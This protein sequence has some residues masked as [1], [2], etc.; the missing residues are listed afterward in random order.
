METVAVI[1]IDLAKNVFQVHGSDATGRRVFNKSLRRASVAKFFA[2]LP[3]CLVGMEACGSSHYW[4]R[5]ISDLGHDVKLMPPQYVKPYVK[6]NKNDA[7]DAAD[8]E[9]ICEAVT[10]PSMRFVEVKTEDQQTLLLIH[11]ERD[12]LVKDRT[13]LIN[14]LWA[15]LGEFGIAVPAG[16]GRLKR[17]FRESYGE[18]E[19]ELPPL[20]RRH[21]QRM[22]IRL[23]EL[24]R[25]I[26]DLDAEID[27]DIARND[28]CRRLLEVP[29]IGR[30]SASAL[31]ASV[32]NGHAFKS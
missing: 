10:R 5:V 16:P 1:G 22:R 20:M 6:T 23:T 11:R 25:C 24:E 2:N 12:G 32:G 17:W 30:L 15:T 3:P 9:A 4:G 29:G 28:A 31:V 18:R 8:A 21:I 27:R 14:R 7:A 19:S 13:A 26:A